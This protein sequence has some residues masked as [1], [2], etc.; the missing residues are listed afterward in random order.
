MVATGI[1]PGTSLGTAPGASLAARRTTGAISAGTGA[2]V[3]A[4]G[5]TIGATGA[6]IRT[7]RATIF[8]GFAGNTSSGQGKNR[9]GRRDEKGF[10][11]V[12]EKFPPRHLL[13]IFFF[14]HSHSPSINR[15]WKYSGPT[16]SLSLFRVAMM[17]RTRRPF[18]TAKVRRLFSNN[19]T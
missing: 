15:F 6:T 8:T 13:V 5:T 2:G 7:A 12:F 3:G 14:F 11:H 1:A 16:L 10:S 18:P 17:L 4:T 19:R 9:I